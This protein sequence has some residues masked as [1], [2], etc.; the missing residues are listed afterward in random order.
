MFSIYSYIVTFVFSS[1]GRHTSGALVTG[2]QTC[3]L[4]IWI[5]DEAGADRRQIAEGRHRPWSW[6][7]ARPWSRAL[8]LA[9]SIAEELPEELL[10]RRSRR[11]QNGRASWRERECQ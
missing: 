2:V 8:T 5:D 1:R 3:A 4:P 9:E 10:E 7:R 6:P 11:K